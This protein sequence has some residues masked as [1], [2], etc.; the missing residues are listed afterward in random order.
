MTEDEKMQVAV[1][2]FSVISDFIHATSMSRREKSR[3]MRDKCGRKWQIPFS[4][5]TRI[6][7][8]T[9]Q[10][11]C[12]IYR[13]SGGDLKSLYPRDRSDQ[14]KARAMDE[15]TCLS[16]IELRRQMPALTVPQLIEQ[17]SRQ[18]RVTPGIVLNNSTIYRFLHQQSLMAPQMKKPVDRRKF[19]AELPNDLW[20]SDVMH[21]PKVDVDG[22]MR[23]T[24]L[25]AIIDDH[26]RLIVHARFYL[27]E[28]LS[29]YLKAFENAI[30]ARGLPRKLYVDNGA[31]FRSKHLEY[32][33]ASLSISLIHAKPYTPQGKGKIE[34]WFKT[35][36]SSFLPLFKGTGPDQLNEALTRW[37]SDRYH[38]KIHS[39]TGQ[40]PFERFTGKMHCLRSSPANLKDYF[41]KV[42]RRTVSKDRSVTLDGRL[43]EA[44]VALIGKRVEL[45]YHDSEPEN[46]EIKYQN[47]SF[48]L[49]RVVDLHVNCRVKRDK[50]NNP[51][52]ES[53][54]LTKYQGGK[55]LSQKGQHHH[56]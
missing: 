12:R 42:A 17:M 43:Y 37:I 24:Y 15:E 26:S 38:K 31:A 35:V 55:L 23:K 54:N 51:Q 33:A 39:A 29:F 5:K 32:I 11:W 18:N 6:S 34:R 53:N 25:I 50:N 8:G 13:N 19:E 28:K 14:G 9:I 3:L 22:K 52:I 49:I 4:E 48:G 7:Q 40:T 47:R 46:V 36:R 20:Q 44:P 2:R 30:A 1:F 10:R 27:S 21:G 41:R 45:L 56:E 16:L